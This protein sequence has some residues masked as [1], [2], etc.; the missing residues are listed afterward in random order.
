MDATMISKEELYKGEY[1]ELK[2]A[3]EYLEISKL[4]LRTFIHE[5]E[6][7]V[8]LMETKKHKNNKYFFKKEDLVE[9]KLFLIMT[10][11]YDKK[12]KCA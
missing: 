4:K 11:F 2:E 8:F 5:G 6:I 7:K 10:N 3:Q 9:F 1:L 12:R